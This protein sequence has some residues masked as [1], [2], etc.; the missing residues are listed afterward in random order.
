MATKSQL[1]LPSPPTFSEMMEDLEIMSGD[2]RL[3]KLFQLEQLPED[4]DKATN[5]TQ[6]SAIEQSHTL[7]NQF[8]SG[9]ENLK[10]LDASLTSQSDSGDD[11][12]EKKLRN[13]IEQLQLCLNKLQSHSF[14]HP[15]NSLS[16]N[17][18]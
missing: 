18:K 9:L 17:G 5:S 15:T 7:A 6:T 14:S 1:E 2:D 3:F 11:Q 4:N 16:S 12:L 13:I 8:L 10:R